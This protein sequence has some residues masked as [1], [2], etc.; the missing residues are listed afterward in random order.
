MP[1]GAVAALPAAAALAA[2]RAIAQ[3][4]RG[5]EGQ[6]HRHRA[7]GDIGEALAGGAVEARDKLCRHG[8]IDCRRS[9]SLSVGSGGTWRGD[10]RKLRGD[11]VPID[12]GGRNARALHLLRGRS[13]DG[14]GE[15]ETRKA[16]F[17]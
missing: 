15:R 8:R 6:Q 16:K 14:S 2:G 12:V 13:Q 17:A 10:R 9:V 1:A 4:G 7:R 3:E 11:R 5:I